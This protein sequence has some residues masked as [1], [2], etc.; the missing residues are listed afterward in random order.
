MFERILISLC[1]LYTQ[2]LGLEQI[3]WRLYD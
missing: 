2:N 3:Y 1:Y